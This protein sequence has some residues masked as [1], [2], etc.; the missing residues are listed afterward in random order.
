MLQMFSWIAANSITSWCIRV[1]AFILEFCC[2]QWGLAAHSYFC[3]GLSKCCNVYCTVLLHL[4]LLWHDSSFLSLC[5]L[6]T[7]TICRVFNRHFSRWPPSDRWISDIMGVAQYQFVCSLFVHFL[8]VSNYLVRICPLEVRWRS[9]VG[10]WP[11]HIHT[12]GRGS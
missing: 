8:F 7:C 2:D 10:I 9:V 1:L 6:R 5:F 4:I 11:R 12:Q 3:I